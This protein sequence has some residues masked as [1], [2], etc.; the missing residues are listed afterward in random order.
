[1]KKILL[2]LSVLI[3]ILIV[4]IEIGNRAQPIQGEKE[5][6]EEDIQEISEVIS[7][8]L[9]KE[10]PAPLPV[11]AFTFNETSVYPGDCISLFISNTKKADDFLVSVPFYDKAISFFPYKSGF[12]GMIPV[13]AWQKAGAYEIKIMDLPQNT[14]TAFS[15]EVLPKEFDVQYLKITETTTAIY[16]DD[17]AAKDQVYFDTARANPIQ[18]K[19]WEGAF[20]QPVQ[21]EITTEYNSQ[22]YTNDNPTP[23]RHLALDIANEAGTP[24]LASNHG[25]VVLAKELIV[26]GNSVVIDHGMGL[27]S[28]SFHLKEITVSEGTLVTKGDEIGTVGS[29]GYSTG[30][31]LHFAFWKEGTFLNPWFFFETDP[32][33]FED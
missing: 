9:P 17:N 30:P 1:M 20:I 5:K 28:S 19:L 15:I 10:A 18:E 31:H 25:K 22:R 27:F 14:E 21:G 32:V 7:P 2:I 6:N 13:Y 26:T 29:T 16:T 3:I 12:V 4:S 33:E 8:S 24:V 23:S 11:T